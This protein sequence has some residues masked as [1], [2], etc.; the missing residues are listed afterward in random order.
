M[1]R[2][3]CLGLQETESE[4]AVCDPARPNPQLALVVPFFELDSD[5]AAQTWNLTLDLGRTWRIMLTVG[6][7]YPC[8]FPWRGI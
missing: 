8:T 6:H 5:V 4:V 3:F 1:C 2:R 7:W